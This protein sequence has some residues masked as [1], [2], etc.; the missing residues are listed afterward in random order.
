M[1]KR[2][3]YLSLGSNQGDRSANILQAV[4]M[5]D[6]GLK[7]PH[8]A[9]SG[10]LAFPSWG[11]NGAEF[12]NCVVRYDLP[13]AGQDLR[14]HAYSILDLA[15]RIEAQMGRLPDPADELSGERIYHDRP[16]DIDI[17]LYGDLNMDEPRL[18][19]PH[20]LMMARGFVLVPL[21]QVATAH[22]RAQIPG[23]FA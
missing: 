22:L 16:I 7:M 12:L 14:L 19:V 2:E 3:L 1:D 20:K 23:I 18:T 9:L 4:R 8:S 15:K 13:A 11:F 21:R 6:E 17:L 10:L 5:L